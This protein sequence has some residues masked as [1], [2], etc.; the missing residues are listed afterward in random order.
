MGVGAVASFNP[1]SYTR[2]FAVLGR[3]QIPAA[4]RER[5][6]RKSPQASY[7]SVAR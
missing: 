2:I 7:L 3:L 1:D 5:T 4:G 6:Q